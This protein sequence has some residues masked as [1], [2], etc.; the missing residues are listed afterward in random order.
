[1]QNNKPKHSSREFKAFLT[2]K[3]EETTLKIMAWSLLKIGLE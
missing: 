3:E 1:M 2:D